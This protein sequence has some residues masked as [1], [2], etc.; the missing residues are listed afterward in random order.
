MSKEGP[1][2]GLLILAVIIAVAMVSPIAGYVVLAGLLGFSLVAW[3]VA[4]V[5]KIGR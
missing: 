1:L 4:V 2:S 5:S 3:F